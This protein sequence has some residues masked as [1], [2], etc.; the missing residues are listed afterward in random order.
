ME[1]SIDGPSTKLVILAASLLLGALFSA[2]EAALD[3]VGAPRLRAAREAGGPGGQVAGRIL[4]HEAALRARLLVGRV[5]S[6][7]GAVW[8]G[9]A[10]APAGVWWLWM[11]STALVT[12]GYAI[13]VRVAMELA[14]R[15]ASGLALPLLRVFRPFELL[16]ALPAAPLIWTSYLV[17]RLFPPKP[18]D[19]PERVTRVEVEYMVEQ[20]EE[21]GSIDRD[22]AELLRSVI[23]FGDTVARE[24]MVPR[25]SMVAVDIETPLSEVMAL[26]VE[27][28]HS[29]YPV[30]RDRIDQLEG[31][32][33]AKD[34]FQLWRDGRL[35]QGDLESVIRRPV[36]FTAES[37]KISKLLRDMQA[38]RV[39]LAIVVD[40]YGGTAGMVAME[41]IIEEIVGEIRDEH[42]YEEPP[43][44]RLG[45][46]RYIVN[47]DVSVDDLAAVTGLQV[48]ADGRDY[49]SL[50]GM[51]AVLAGR[52]LPVG[53]A[54]ELGAHELIVRAGDERRVQKV[55]VVHRGAVV[56]GAA[57]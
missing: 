19:D 52:V 50:G 13:V 47:A 53:E 23:E 34:L 21:L 37:Q 9:Y 18:E 27:K 40:E 38:R 49:D 33:Y 14:A 22:H 15:R 48:P 3:A 17:N 26:I 7:V 39:H 57:E 11:G 31:V 29:R 1:D 54:I 16:V 32:L 8:M 44:R 28:G 5:L 45:P 35:A 51:L 36:F 12:W 30:Y 24:I 25:T 2:V 42:D 41:D 56:A 6:L 10:L 43:V 20:G 55:E 46:G 4:D